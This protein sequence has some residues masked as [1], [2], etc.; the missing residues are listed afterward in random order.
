MVTVRIPPQNRLEDVVHLSEHIAAHLAERFDL[1]V[2][3]DVR[4]M[5][6]YGFSSGLDSEHTLSG[7]MMHPQAL[8]YPD[9]YRIHLYVRGRDP[10]PEHKARRARHR[11]LGSIVITSGSAMIQVPDF[12]FERET[13]KALELY[14]P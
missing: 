13:R 10:L 8:S 12:Q 3:T 7:S 11:P 14:R 4:I 6:G 9:G 1:S 2:R 5:G